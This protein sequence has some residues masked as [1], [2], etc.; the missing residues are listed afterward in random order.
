MSLDKATELSLSPIT[1]LV[2]GLLA[3][4]LRG[5]DRAAQDIPFYREL[6]GKELIEHE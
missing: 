4:R 2:L 6:L 5:A 3:D 1:E